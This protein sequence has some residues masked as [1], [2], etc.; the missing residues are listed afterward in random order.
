MAIA[1]GN[2]V[3]KKCTLYLEISLMAEF[4]TTHLNHLL[5]F[6][7]FFFKFWDYLN[8]EKY[9][10]INFNIDSQHNN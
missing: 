5:F 10:V 8:K 2:N 7:T 4:Q 9:K 6:H 1:D 3:Y